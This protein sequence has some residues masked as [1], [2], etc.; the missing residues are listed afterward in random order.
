M[1]RRLIHQPLMAA[2]TSRYAPFRRLVD[3]TG[4]SLSRLLSMYRLSIDPRRG[5]LPFSVGHIALA[6]AVLSKY[7]ATI[8]ALHYTKLDRFPCCDNTLC[9]GYKFT[10]FN[11]LRRVAMV[12]VRWW[13]IAA[14]RE[15]SVVPYVAFKAV[16]ARCFTEM[17]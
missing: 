3:S 13:I 12:Q 5:Y 4:P 17:N 16:V 9:L 15:R 7:L 11:E 1:A 8:L 10:E 2:E 14:E 6:N